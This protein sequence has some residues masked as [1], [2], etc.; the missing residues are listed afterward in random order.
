MNE[1]SQYRGSAG[2]LGAPLAIGFVLG[3][4]LGA[5]IALLLAPASGE[6][7]RRRVTDT[8]RSLGGAARRQVDRVIETAGDLQQNAGAALKAG[9]EAFDQA[10][11][12]P[13][14]PVS[15]G[16]RS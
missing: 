16:S 14:P 2:A 8:A 1:N 3:A 4:V 13:T 11:S 6:E 10:N 5:G 15:A 7:T 12:T 9:R